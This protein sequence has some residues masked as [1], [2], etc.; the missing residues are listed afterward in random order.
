MTKHLKR[1]LKNIEDDNKKPIEQ[2]NIEDYMILTNFQPNIEYPPTILK[3]L[4][5]EKAIRALFAKVNEVIYKL[6][7]KEEK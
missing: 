6:E 5:Y 2:L 1:L 7:E 3:K 4:N